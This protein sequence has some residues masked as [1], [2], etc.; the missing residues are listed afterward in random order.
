MKGITNK[1]LNI[2]LFIFNFFLLILLLFLITFNL[3]S[4]VT[5]ETN[6]FEKIQNY[7]L[8]YSTKP[9]IGFICVVGSIS[10][11]CCLVNFFMYKEISSLTYITER[12]TVSISQLIRI[13]QIFLEKININSELKSRTI[14][15]LEFLLKEVA[16]IVKK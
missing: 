16:Q 3:S 14:L 10:I 6:S 2:F 12:L 4:L 8:L 15:L 5:V 11:F 13:E 9:E 7:Y 1:I